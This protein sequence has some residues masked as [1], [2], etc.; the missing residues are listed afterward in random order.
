MSDLGEKHILA[1]VYI[2]Y[3]PE[4]DRYF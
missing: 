1:S 2:P 4:W 3:K